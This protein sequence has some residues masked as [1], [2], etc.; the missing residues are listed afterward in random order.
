M[1]FCVRTISHV[2]VAVWC[3]DY[4]HTIDTVTSFAANIVQLLKNTE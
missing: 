2:K 4:R 1:L 3:K